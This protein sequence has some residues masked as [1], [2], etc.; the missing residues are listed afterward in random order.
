MSRSKNRGSVNIAL[1][2]VG[3]G[4]LLSGVALKWLYFRPPAA[5]A[6]TVRWNLPGAGTDA[7]VL[8]LR[9]GLGPEALCAVG[10][11]IDSTVGGIVAN[12]LAELANDPT[13]LESADAA[14]ATARGIADPLGRKIRSGLAS[15]AE[16]LAYNTAMTDL[17]TAEAAQAARLAEC[18]AAGTQ[19]MLQDQI[20]ALQS[21]EEQAATWDAVP[22]AYRLVTRTQTDWMALRAALANE[23]ISAKSEGEEEIDPECAALLATVRAEPLVAAALV[24]LSTFGTSVE[25]AWKEACRGQ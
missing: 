16:I 23:R 25:T 12:V 1:L 6:T 17:A 4:V 10:V 21:I 15:E 20:T 3:A 11:V 22:V 7:E 24:N 13:A 9:C 5:S 19:G 2:T 14:V 8:M 18:F